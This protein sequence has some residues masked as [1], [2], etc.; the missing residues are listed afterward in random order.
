MFYH[1]DLVTVSV[2]LST[3]SAVSSAFIIFCYHR[4]NLRGFLYN[5]IVCMAYNDL[6]MAIGNMMGAQGRESD[7]GCQLQAFLVGFFGLSSVLWSTAIAYTLRRIFVSGDEIYYV[8]VQSNFY[9]RMY[10]IICQGIPAVLAILPVFTNGWGDTGGWCWI[11]DN[12]AVNTMWRFVTYYIWIWTCLVYNLGIYVSVLRQIIKL[13]EM[14]VLEESTALKNLRKLKYFPL[15]MVAS[16][17]WAT[18]NRLYECFGA[19]IFWLCLLHVSFTSLMGFFNALAYGYTLE[20]R[21]TGYL[22][23][24]GDSSSMLQAEER[25]VKNVEWEAADVKSVRSLED[26]ETVE[27]TKREDDNVIRLNPRNDDWLASA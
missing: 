7:F 19:P 25:Q 5:L 17:F 13:D 24:P 3:L 15:A 27:C 14:H 11:K 10:A 9:F 16:Q 12:N 4:I 1:E 8:T 26:M 23:A 20:D 22:F 2:S 6:G 18:I 21:I